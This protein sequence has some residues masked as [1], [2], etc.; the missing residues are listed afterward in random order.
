MTRDAQQKLDASAT[1]QYRLAYTV[2]DATGHAV[3]GAYLF[4]VRGQ[5]FTGAGFRFNHLE[6]VTDSRNI[7]RGARCA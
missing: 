6:L 1:G 5:G 3:E 2:T 7:S 4:T